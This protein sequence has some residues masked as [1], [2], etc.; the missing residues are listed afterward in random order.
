[1]KK[2][3]QR[4]CVIC[5]GK[6]DKRD[7]LRIVVDKSGRIFFD[8]TGKQNGRGAYVCQSQDCLNKFSGKNYLE[9]IFK[10]K[11]EAEVQQEIQQE[12]SEIMMKKI[13]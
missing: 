3:P 6:F 10:R 4:T 8:P 9:R 13:K 7:L 1:M 5:Q 11:V 2:I 12:I